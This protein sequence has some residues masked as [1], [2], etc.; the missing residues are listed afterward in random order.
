MTERPEVIKAVAIAR[1]FGDLSENAEYKAAK[2]RQR[3]IDSEIDYLRRR[4]AHLKVVDTSQFPKDAVR[5]GSYCLATDEATQEQI[6]YQVV[7]AE[8]LNFTNEEG[9][10]AVSVVSPIGKA[11]LSKKVGEIAIVDAP[12]G[13]RNLKIIEIK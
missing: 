11:L 4:A 8:E 10:Q 6:C 12:M 1:E 9:V 7:G 3:S 5:F 2:E 13:K